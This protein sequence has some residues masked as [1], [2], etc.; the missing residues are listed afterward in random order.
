[1]AL[2]EENEATIKININPFIAMMLLENDRKKRE[3]GNP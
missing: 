2:E 1:M 3:T